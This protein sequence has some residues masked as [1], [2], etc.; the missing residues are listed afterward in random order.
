MSDLFIDDTA[1]DVDVRRQLARETAQ[2][3]VKVDKKLTPAQK[4]RRLLEQERELASLVFQVEEPPPKAAEIEDDE[5]GAEVSEEDAEDDADEEDEEEVDYE[6]EAPAQP[7]AAGAAVSAVP[8]PFTQHLEE[9]AAPAWV[10]EDDEEQSVNVSGRAK[11]K[12][13]LK[14]LRQSRT[15]TTLSGSE[16][17]DGLR[18]QFESVQPDVSWAV[19]PPPEAASKRSRSKGGGASDAAHERDEDGDEEEEDDEDDEE[20]MDAVLRSGS[21]LLGA[22]SALPSSIL[23]VR[24]LTDL[25]LRERSASM[26]T[27]V[28][29]HPNGRLALTAGPDKTLRLFR[30]DGTGN[31]KL[32]SVHLPKTP[33][34]SAAFSAD[35]SQVFMCGKGKLW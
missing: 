20:E 28:Q 14:K 27:S 19:L 11:G 25:N 4:R 5:D 23:S 7:M 3:Q 8:V 16:Y 26:T 17:V 21:S 6:D 24:R 30:S 2:A 29:W 1:G 34:N 12:A 35:G 10:D 31:P 9:E 18:R 15:Q 33:I 22:S 13:R 32:Q